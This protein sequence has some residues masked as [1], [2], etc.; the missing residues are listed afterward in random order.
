MRLAL[1]ALLLLSACMVNITDKRLTRE[2]VSAAFKQRDNAIMGLATIVK[3]LK[4]KN[5]KTSSGTS[6]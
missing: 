4:E 6:K 5:E 1:G 3:E 2:E